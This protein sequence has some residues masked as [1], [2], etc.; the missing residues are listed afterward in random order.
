[1]AVRKPL[2]IVAGEIQQLQSGD[3]IDVPVSGGN[4]VTA[5]NDNAGSVVIGAPVYVSSAGGV[6]KARA[7]AIGTKDVVGL[8]R[9]VTTA[10]GASGQV[11][12]DGVLAASTAQ[13]DAV[14]GTTGGLTAGARM[15]LD[16]ATAGKITATA[17]STT[18]Q[19]VVSIGIALSTTE[20]LVDI[21]QPILL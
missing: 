7:N 10:T 15:F 14:A 2:V 5:D 21:E 12:T 4:V 16:A 8:M 17:P 3:T 11:Q 13:W 9:D 6:D 18:G 20:L 1:M 19:Y